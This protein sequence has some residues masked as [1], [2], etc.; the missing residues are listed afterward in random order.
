MALHF[1]T[2]G[3]DADDTPVIRME[4]MIDCVFL[5]IIF[6]LTTTAFIPLEQDLSINLPTMSEELRVKSPPARQIVV[7]VRYAPGGAASY[8]VD[9]EPRTLA[10][11]KQNFSRAQLRNPDQRVVVRGDKRVK[12]DQI[13]TVMGAAAEAGITKVSASLEVREN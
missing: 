12:W 1:D 13:A 8:V 2:E 5:L 10:A 7:N 3:E 11:L 6:F 4:P 9:N